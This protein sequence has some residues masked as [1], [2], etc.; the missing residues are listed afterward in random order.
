MRQQNQPT[1]KDMIELPGPFTFKV[2]VKPGMVSGGQLQTLASDKLGRF[3]QCEAKGT[4]HSR[5]GK[6]TAHTLVIH[7]EAYEEIE[8]LY[9]AFKSLDGV[10]MTL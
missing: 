10:V 5:T 6:Y 1:A 8:T 7:I 2:F 9:L 3:I 4:N